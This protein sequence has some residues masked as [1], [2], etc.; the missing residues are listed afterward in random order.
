[1]VLFP[2]V[3]ETWSD[4]LVPACRTLVLRLIVASS[5]RYPGIISV[6]ISTSSGPSKDSRLAV[7]QLAMR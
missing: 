5:T 6:D 2:V 4:L 3:A 1:M 7:R